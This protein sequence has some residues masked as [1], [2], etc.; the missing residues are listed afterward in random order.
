MLPNNIILKLLLIQFFVAG[1]SGC[2]A[3]PPKKEQAANLTNLTQ[4]TSIERL[5]PE[6]EK[7]L[8]EAEKQQLNFYSRINFPEAKDAFEELKNKRKEFNPEHSGFFSSGYSE[9]DLFD[10]QKE[11]NNYISKAYLAK[12]NIEGNMKKLLADLTYLK[13][14]DIQN[15]KLK[16]QYQNI[17]DDN[18]SLFKKV[19][20]AG[21]YEPYAEIKQELLNSIVELEFDFMVARYHTP[22]LERFNRVENELVPQTHKNTFIVLGGLK[23][24]IKSDSRNIVRMEKSTAAAEKAVTR[25]E[26]VLAEVKWVKDIKSDSAEE[27]VLKYRNPVDESLPALLDK[28]VSELPFSEQF[29]VYAQQISSMQTRMQQKVQKTESTEIEKQAQLMASAESELIR[30]ELKK[31]FDAELQTKIAE[32]SSAGDKQRLLSKQKAAEQE[33]ELLLAQQK[34]DELTKQL[35]E[36]K[37]QAAAI[38]EPGTETQKKMIAQTDDTNESQVT[39][40]G[41]DVV[42]DFDFN[43]GG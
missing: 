33:S 19:D 13:T 15:K 11:F 9:Q 34:V 7:T 29:V 12:S 20:D 42:V 24:E 39:E 41:E 3:T 6:A 26:S 4:P 2:L 18:D 5:V 38:D 40:E 43:I 8:A 16:S 28:D 17:L 27:I 22:L 31:E 14:L 23:S 32:I 21:A 10:Q 25:L 1:L 37:Q 30:Q 35:S 36:L